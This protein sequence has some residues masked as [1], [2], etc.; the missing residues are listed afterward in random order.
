MATFVNSFGPVSGLNNASGAYSGTVYQ[1]GYA[2]KNF[3][4]QS[5]Q[6]GTLSGASSICVMGSLDGI[7][8]YPLMSAGISGMF[9]GG[10]SGA[11]VTYASVNLTLASGAL[12]AA[13]SLNLN[14]LLWAN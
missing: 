7:T 5:Y 14:T 6:S 3:A 4:V 10:V 2:C 12:G 13:N 8:M 1:F 9:F 11:G